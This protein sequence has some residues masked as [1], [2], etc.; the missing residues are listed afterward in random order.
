MHLLITFGDDNRSKSVSLLM[1]EPET[2]ETNQRLVDA[3]EGGCG[4]RYMLDGDDAR[5]MTDEEQQEEFLELRIAAAGPMNRHKRNMLLSETD[6]T[7]VADVALTNEE[8]AE[9]VTYRAFLR[10]IT[11]HANW[12][13]LEDGDWPTA[14]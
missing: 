3:P 2:I 14:P 6:W 12:P 7:Q 10:D 4:G 13:L 9:Y 8:T 1:E 5:A 11:E